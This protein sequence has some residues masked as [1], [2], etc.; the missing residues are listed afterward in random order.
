MYLQVPV[1]DWSLTLVESGNSFTGITEYVE[2]LRFCESYM[3]PLVH[4]LHHLTS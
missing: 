4:L 1:N 2:H 3:Q